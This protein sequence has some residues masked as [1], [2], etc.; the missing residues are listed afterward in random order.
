MRAAPGATWRTLAAHVHHSLGYDRPLPY[1]RAAEGIVRPLRRLAGSTA[2]ARG[3][4]WLVLSPV[5]SGVQSPP[6]R[7][8]ADPARPS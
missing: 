2:Y 6:S 3:S 8:E 5:L 7:G 4:S 1:I